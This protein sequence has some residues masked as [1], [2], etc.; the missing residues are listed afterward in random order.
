MLLQVLSKWQLLTSEGGV[1]LRIW[2]DCYTYWA[3]LCWD[4]HK[5]QTG[6]K[7]LG[8]G[9]I[10]FILHTH[11]PCLIHR[12]RWPTGISKQLCVLPQQN[13]FPIMILKCQNA[14]HCILFTFQEPPP[15]PRNQHSSPVKKNLKMLFTV[16]FLGSLID[17][18]DLWHF[19]VT[20]IW[21]TSLHL[22]IVQTLR[23][24]Q[25]YTGISNHCI[26]R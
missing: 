17:N 23:K 5:A 25:F 21:Q 20:Y 19:M 7:G 22:W 3:P 26:S 12:K 6:G 11:R 1:L 2:H 18:T 14:R 15:S 16:E 8:T 10:F 24:N 9:A 4:C 13:T